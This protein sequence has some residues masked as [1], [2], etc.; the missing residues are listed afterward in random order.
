METHLVLIAKGEGVVLRPGILITP[1]TV[2]DS[3]PRTKNYPAQN[4]TSAEGEK[5]CFAI[6]GLKLYSL[7]TA[8]AFLIEPDKPNNPLN[9]AD[10]MLWK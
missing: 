8:P 2:Q 7:E 5:P 9:N 6:G 4:V 10:E 1:Y 3:A